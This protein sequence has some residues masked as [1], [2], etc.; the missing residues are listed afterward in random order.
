M[1][2]STIWLAGLALASACKHDTPRPPAAYANFKLPADAQAT[3]AL[4]F[5]NTS[6]NAVRYRWAFGDG[7]MD[8]APNPTHTYA[9][10]GTYSVTLHAYGA[11]NDSTYTIIDLVVKE[12]DILTHTP[13]KV[14]GQYDYTL[15]RRTKMGYPTAPE[16]STY[17]GT[18][19]ATITSV[20]SSKIAITTPDFVTEATYDPTATMTGPTGKLSF[21]FGDVRVEYGTAT[22]YVSGDSLFLVHVKAPGHYGY[23]ADYYRGHRRP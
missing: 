4:S 11:G 3:D 9:K 15:V 12:Y 22:F 6:G 14:V 23:V 21:N 8:T 13:I 5:Q 2:Y 19:S 7:A 16:I 18:G 1:K 10:A 17:E 20:G